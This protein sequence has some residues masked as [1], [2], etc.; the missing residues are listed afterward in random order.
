MLCGGT[1]IGLYQPEN[2]EI[3]Y[4]WIPLELLL[5]PYKNFPRKNSWN[6]LYM[7]TNWEHGIL[8]CRAALR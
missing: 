6:I 8:Y 5:I 4:I 7:L 3:S 1:I 2:I